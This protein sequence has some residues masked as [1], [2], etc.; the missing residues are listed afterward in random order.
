MQRWATLHLGTASWA[1]PWPC[2]LTPLDYHLPAAARWFFPAT[3]WL[4]VGSIFIQTEGRMPGAELTHTASWSTLV[5][6]GVFPSQL[7]P[8]LA[9]LLLK[10]DKISAGGGRIAGKCSPL[11]CDTWLGQELGVQNLQ[12]TPLPL[13]LWECKHHHHPSPHTSPVPRPSE[14]LKDSRTMAVLSFA[15]AHFTALKGF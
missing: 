14:L 9:V 6:L 7:W 10:S 12:K 13:V 4:E 5:F 3:A 8:N 11:P 2:L 1:L 15:A